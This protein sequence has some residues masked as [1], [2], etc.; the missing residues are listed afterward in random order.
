MGER[1][2][3]ANCWL[4]GVARAQRATTTLNIFPAGKKAATPFGFEVLHPL[5]GFLAGG[6]LHSS[7][8][9]PPLRA[10]GG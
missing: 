5:V 3:N 1:C 2:W 8:R 6:S 9:Y 4:V 10:G 7:W